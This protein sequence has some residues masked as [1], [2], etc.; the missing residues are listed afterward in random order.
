M[1]Q[2]HWK[3]VTIRR[4]HRLSQAAPARPNN[5]A[6]NGVRLLHQSWQGLD[7]AVQPL[8]TALNQPRTLYSGTN[9]RLVYEFVSGTARGVPAAALPAAA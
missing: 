6:V 4:P 2:I 8:L 9:L 7:E 1:L 3:S 5:P